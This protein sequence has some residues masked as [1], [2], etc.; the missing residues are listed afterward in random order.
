MSTKA[1]CNP[2]A[3]KVPAIS[4]ATLRALVLVVGKD[5]VAAAAVNVDGLRPDGLESWP[6]T[7][8]ANRADRAPK[9]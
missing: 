4:A 5:E 6:S 9:G 7:Q 8:G 3:N 1:L 2:V